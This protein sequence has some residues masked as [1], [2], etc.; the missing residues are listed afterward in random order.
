MIRVLRLV[1]ILCFV[2][3]T[4]MSNFIPQR[5]QLHISL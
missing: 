2:A 4:T 3:M 1:F 5:K